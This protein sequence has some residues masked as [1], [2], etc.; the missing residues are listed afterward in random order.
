[1]PMDGLPPK[2]RPIV[3]I[4][5]R[6]SASNPARYAVF[7][8]DANKI[9]VASYG[10]DYVVAPTAE[11]F[12]SLVAQW[13]QETAKLSITKQK[14]RSLFFLQIIGLSDRAL[15]YIFQEFG[16][17]K[18]PAWPIALEAITRQNPAK[19]IAN[20]EDVVSAWLDWGEK[21]GYRG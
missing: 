6:P 15:L 8:V 12:A 3:A 1:M 13:K 21:N 10:T 9:T 4:L 2:D 20:Y 14:V 17:T 19:D 11:T 18:N 16:K 7:D 5:D